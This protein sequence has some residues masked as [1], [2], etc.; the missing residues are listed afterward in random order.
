L[1]RTHGNLA[2]FIS[3][4]LKGTLINVLTAGIPTA[5]LANA[6]NHIPATAHTPQVQT[7]FFHNFVRHMAP[8]IVAY[9][10]LHS[11]T[12]KTEIQDKP[13]RCREAGQ[14]HV[15]FLR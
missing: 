7:A 9:R 15:N 13:T 1:P 12:N 14:E 11:I 3:P 5:V 6:P 8:K 2:I 4:I 10:N